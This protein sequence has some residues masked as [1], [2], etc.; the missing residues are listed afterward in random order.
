M[1]SDRVLG[2]HKH[3]TICKGSKVDVI[4][5]AYYY[6]ATCWMNKYANST[7]RKNKNK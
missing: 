2:Y 3:C 1:S 4:Q 7:R 6:C 5:M